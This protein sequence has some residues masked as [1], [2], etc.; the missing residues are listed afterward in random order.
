MN[1]LIKTDFAI[2]VGFDVTSAQIKNAVDDTNSFLKTL[3]VLLFTSIDFKT[4]GSAIGA[5]FCDKLATNIPGA[6]VNPIEKGHPDII[7]SS[8]LGE[9]EQSLRNFPNGLEIKGTIGNIKKGA[10]LRAGQKRIAQLTGITWQAHHREVE[11]LLGFV[12]DFNDE[13]EGFHFPVIVGV[14]YFDKLEISD[15]GE[16][17]GT[18]GRNTK[19]SAM[20]KSG[21]E[22]M[23][24]GW[25]LMLDDP[26]YL[27]KL[28]S[29][30]SI[31][32][33]KD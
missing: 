11:H 25:I 13:Y 28:R 1:Y 21:K 10:N 23:G 16:I 27:A 12:W 2:N 19:V 18:T 6:A 32:E 17:S 26:D 30:L 24:K 5:I 33:V 29:Y 31:I 15:W 7:P 14:F 20:L 3:P 22:K 4:I 8:A 9:T